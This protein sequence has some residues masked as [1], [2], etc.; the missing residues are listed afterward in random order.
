MNRLFIIVCSLVVLSGQAVAATY[1]AASCSSAHVQAAIDLATSNGDV[2]T[3]PGTS[4]PWTSGVTI[5]AAKITLQGVGTQA[6][7]WSTIITVSGA[8]VAVNIGATGSRVTG[9]D[10]QMSDEGGYGVYALAGN[11]L[12]IDNN[13]IDFRPDV[14]GSGG[15]EAIAVSML[16]NNYPANTVNGLIHHNDIH[17]GV[18][19]I[20]GPACSSCER[21]WFAIMGAALDLGGPTALYIEDNKFY[22]Y[23]RYGNI[24]DTNYG[25]SYVFRY[26]TVEKA[27]TSQAY[28][29]ETHS[30]WAGRGSK[31]FEIYRNSIYGADNTGVYK[32]RGGTGV[33]FDETVTGTWNQKNILLSNRRSLE[34]GVVYCDGS[35]AVDGNETITTAVYE[36]AGTGTHT[37]ADGATLTDSAKAWTVDKL[38]GYTVYNL[39]DAPAKCKITDNDGTTV[40]CTLSGG[41]RDHWHG[42][43]SPDSYRISDGYPCRDQI[44]RGADNPACTAETCAAGS[45]YPA[46]PLVPTYGW[47]N[48]SGVTFL[49][50]S[51][52]ANHIIANRDFY[53]YNA[54]CTGAACTTGVGTG[55]TKP[56][57]CTTGTGFWVTNE[58]SWNKKPAGVQGVLYKCTA[59][60]TWTSYYTPY[61][62]PHPNQ[63]YTATPTLTLTGT[64]TGK[65]Q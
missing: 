10:F 55:T 13:R 33:I 34:G 7:G 44:G 52:G 32:I 46:Q 2:V 22:E 3:V 40:T 23:I 53:D 42:D 26:N 60:D 24:V 38:I 63:N 20:G 50:E 58:G 36:S 31:K 48:S 57:S 64:T 19:T 14:T 17:D 25:G 21:E 1:N 51:P 45:A 47:G 27:V 65:L 59:T 49:N 11:G 12:I 39:S 56:T 29:V 30:L 6:G 37:A 5:S 18:V 16:N 54:A 28:V 43:P 4:C 35:S 9:F 15:R 61:E 62:Y 41:T 8:I